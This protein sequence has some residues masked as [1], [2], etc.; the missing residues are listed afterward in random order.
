MRKHARIAVHQRKNKS[1]GPVR[2]VPL[3]DRGLAAYK[4]L[5]KGKDSGESLHMVN[6]KVK[7]Q[8]AAVRPMTDIR[9]WFDEVLADAK[10]T[11]DPASWHVCR[12]TF[13]SRAVAKGVPITD[14]RRCRPLGPALN[15]KVHSRGRRRLRCQEQRRNEREGKLSNDHLK[16]SLCRN[17]L[18]R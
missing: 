2:Y 16:W 11:D 8:R 4:R 6:M 9:F 14:V 7:D 13:C 3:S 15:V 17:R 12:H 5:A 10:I 1:A 18:R